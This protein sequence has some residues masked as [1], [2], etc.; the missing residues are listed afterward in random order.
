MLAYMFTPF[1]I[2]PAQRECYL[3]LIYAPQMRNKN[4]KYILFLFFHTTII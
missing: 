3:S 1:R 2:E 4:K